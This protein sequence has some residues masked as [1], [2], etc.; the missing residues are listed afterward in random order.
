MMVP[1]LAHG[2]SSEAPASA[3]GTLSRVSL[4]GLFQGWSDPTLKP[5]YSMLLLSRDAT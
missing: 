5:I 4:Q 3:I 1:K 2:E